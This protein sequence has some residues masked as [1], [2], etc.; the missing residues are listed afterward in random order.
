[1]LCR[2]VR[3]PAEDEHVAGGEAVG[4]DR[5]QPARGALDQ[6]LGARD[7]SRP[8]SPAALSAQPES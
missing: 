3:A 6:R 4:G 1:M 8:A 5:I 2:Q 7:R